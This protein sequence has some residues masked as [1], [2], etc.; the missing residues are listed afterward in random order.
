MAS[1]HLSLGERRS[2]P[3]EGI[4][5]VAYLGRITAGGHG[6]G[7]VPA[8]SVGRARKGRGRRGYNPLPLS[9]LRPC[10]SSIVEAVMA[11]KKRATQL[12]PGEH[13]NSSGQMLFLLCKS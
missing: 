2:K 6:G 3:G 7:S 11:G 12:W 10:G 9:S 13:H 1:G 5:R 4:G 8:W